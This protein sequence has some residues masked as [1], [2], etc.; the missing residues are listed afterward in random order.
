MLRRFSNTAAPNSPRHSIRFRPRGFF[1]R[2]VGAAQAL[3]FC[4]AKLRHE[5]LLP[6][7]A[8]TQPDSYAAL[9][10]RH[11]RVEVATGAPFC[12]FSKSRARRG[13]DERVGR[14]TTLVATES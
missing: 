9:L 8:P 10:P 2:A 3:R 6:E 12:V 14:V 11:G 5:C 4:F 1:I 13:A 7:S